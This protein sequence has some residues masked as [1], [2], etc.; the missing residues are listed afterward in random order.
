MYEFIKNN[1]VLER[2]MSIILILS[3]SVLAFSLDFIV[4]DDIYGETKEQKK[5]VVIDA[6]HGG[7]DPGKIAVTG[8]YEQEI[9][10]QIALKLKKALEKKDYQVILTRKDENH[11]CK[12]KFIKL[13]DMNNRC[14]IVNDA[15]EN[16]NSTI[17]I[18]IHQNSYENQQI[19]GAQCFYYGTSS[20]SKQ[21][22]TNIQEHLNKQIN[23]DNEKEEKKSSSYYI[24]RKTNCPAVIVECG[25]LSNYLEAENLVTSKHQE[26]IV[27]C[28][29]KGI[30][31][32]K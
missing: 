4:D 19:H 14:K 7:K 9:N 1:V 11:L 21:L 6:G 32:D 24:L 2:I 28:I 10:L 5:V 17:L 25:F 8:V 15:F 20:K 3:I 13:E 12:D 22:A 30:E 18:S 27:D 16:N 29:I 23:I 26:K 31:K